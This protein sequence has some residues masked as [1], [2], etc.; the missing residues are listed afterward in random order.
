[1]DCL[2][3]NRGGSLTCAKLNRQLPSLERSRMISLLDGVTMKRFAL[4]M[5]TF[6]IVSCQTSPKGRQQLMLIPAD[7]MDAMGIQAFNEMKQQQ[8]VDNDP[9]NNAYVKCIANALTGAMDEKQTWEV[10][11]FK[12][13]SPNAFALPG[14]KI[15]VHTGM[16]KVA[17]TADQLAAVVGHE[18]GHVIA[19]HGNERVSEQ[20]V[21]QGGL[22]LLAT[23]MDERNQ[24]FGLIMAGL[25]LGAQFGILLPHSRTQESEADI[26]GLDLMAKAGFNPEESVQLWKNMEQAGG[27]QPPEFLS[28]HPS[29]GTRMENL[30]SNMSTALKMYKKAPSHPDCKR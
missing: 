21:A 15:G 25:G 17:K 28:T 16:F 29:H 2:C 3:E 14:G 26:I 30:A 27:G 5:L 1:M 22:A 10:V 13:D 11:V 6:L 20:L 18:I 8:P 12:D 9:K 7:Q 23:A 24:N 4:L 19:Q